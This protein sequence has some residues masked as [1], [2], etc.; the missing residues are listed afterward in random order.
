MFK[1]Y[2]IKYNYNYIQQRIYFL[3]STLFIFLSEETLDALLTLL[4]WRHN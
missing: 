3:Q 2:L 4:G 1:E